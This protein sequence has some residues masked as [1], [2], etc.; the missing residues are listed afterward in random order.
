M[1]ACALPLTLA[2]IDGQLVR[3]KA[4]R[5]GGTSCSCSITESVESLR[6]VGPSTSAAWAARGDVVTASAISS[7]PMLDLAALLDLFA[8]HRAAA[9]TPPVASSSWSTDHGR[10]VGL[11]VDEV[12]RVR[13]QVVV[14]SLEA[15]YHRVAR[16]DAGATI[17]GDGQVAFILDVVALVQAARAPSLIAAAA[18]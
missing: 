6:A 13:Q 3:L 8:P 12:H 10:K 16:P 15:N 5:P 7:M 1:H 4:E 14:K 17:L 18:A 11:L 2:I 9:P